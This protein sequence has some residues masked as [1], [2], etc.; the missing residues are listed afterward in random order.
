MNK[1]EWANMS[2]LNPSP[3]DSV[4]QMNPSP[5]T[6]RAEGAAMWP[7]TALAA[8]TAGLAR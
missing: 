3:I 2:Q 6:Q 8:A 5:M 4:S 1:G 7:A